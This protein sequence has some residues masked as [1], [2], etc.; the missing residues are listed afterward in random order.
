MYRSSLTI[1]EGISESAWVQ[2]SNKA[3]PHYTW[4]Y[5]APYVVIP[6]TYIVPSLYVM[7]YQEILAVSLQEFQFPHYT[8][9]YITE[10][11][12]LDMQTVVPSLYVRVYR[13][14]AA[15]DIKEKCSLTIREGISMRTIKES[16]FRGFPHYTWGY[17]ALSASLSRGARVPSL[18]VRVY[19]SIKIFLKLAQRSLTIREGISM[20][21]YVFFIKCAFP[22]Y[23]WGYIGRRGDNWF[24]WSVPSLYV[25]VYRS[26]RGLFAD[27]SGSLTIRE[28]ISFCPDFLQG[29][30]LFPHYMWWYIGHFRFFQNHSY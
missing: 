16:Y 21:S 14:D 28:G 7:V 12:V 1:R 8:W 15:D 25:R 30:K 17:I 29:V 23:T 20:L 5:I 11:S 9:G 19:R 10:C 22:H 3:F 24:K 26:Y 6:H 2:K 13:K 27:R 4:G 18:Y